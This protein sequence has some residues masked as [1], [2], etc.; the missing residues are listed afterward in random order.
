M[1]IL[2]LTLITSLWENSLFQMVVKELTLAI[3]VL[4]VLCTFT[5]FPR[6]FLPLL[7]VLV[8]IGKEGLQMHNISV[9][10]KN[11]RPGKSAGSLQKPSYLCNFQIV[12]DFMNGTSS[13]SSL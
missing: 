2:V 9:N 5:I 6:F 8:S 7:S 3:S 10:K 13:P 11:D 4:L 12:E 1:Q